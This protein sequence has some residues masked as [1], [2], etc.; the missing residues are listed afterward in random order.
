MH[1]TDRPMTNA[2]G[3]G[4][5]AEWRRNWTVVLACFLGTVIMSIPTYGTGV[6][7]EPLQREFGWSRA[8]ISAGLTIYAVVGMIGL[9]LAGL[10]LDR[11]GVR[12]V[13]LCGTVLFC[14][15]I[16]GVSQVSSDVRTWWL[17]WALIGFSALWI[18]PAI[19]SKAITSCFVHGRGLAL[20]IM[21]SGSGLATMV[22]PPL[23]LLLIDRFGWRGA[24]PGLAVLSMVVI[25]PVMWLFLYEAGDRVPGR[26]AGSR[27]TPA[28][29]LAARAE[30]AE[31]TRLQPGWTRAEG[32]RCRQTYHL[33]VVAFISTCFI[34]GYAVHLLPMLTGMGLDRPHAAALVS[35]AGVLAIVGRV[36]VGHIFD[37][38]QHPAV[39]AITVAIPILPALFLLLLP[40]HPLVLTAS[41]V[42]VGF[43]I[44]GEYDAV[45][46]VS[47][48][49]FGLK[50]FG[51]LY[52]IVG[53]AMALGVGAGPV[54]AG[55]IYDVTGS[56]TGFLIAT[57]PAAL[58]A[59]VLMVTL[60]RYPD[61]ADPAVLPVEV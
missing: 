47:G 42:V 56:Y 12:R 17:A 19:W 1:G 16:A 5:G 60:G 28:E 33:A 3:A 57:I 10:V 6:F 49:F 24:F 44:G 30:A 48:R 26:Q 15:V 34:A 20:A 43:A 25:F 50:A 11:Y 53:S 41:A 39:G 40:P 27:P 55:H 52:G 2:A 35:L 46:Y 14:L 23:E 32:L 9:P 7:I 8:A 59:V 45:A 61:H 38:I 51:F 22:F 29:R 21:A 54:I 36:V 4:A 58:V 13:A 31:R 37:R 18:K